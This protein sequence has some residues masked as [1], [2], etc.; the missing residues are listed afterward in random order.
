M[1]ITP[2]ILA[3]AIAAS[4]TIGGAVGSLSAAATVS[5]ASP[6]AIAAAVQ[7]V[8]DSSAESTLAQIETML[9]RELAASRK[10]SQE[11]CRNTAPE[12]HLPNCTGY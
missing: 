8:R 11:I 7:K 2:R 10:L 5:E 1:T 4:A 3:A 6:T 12:G 9:T